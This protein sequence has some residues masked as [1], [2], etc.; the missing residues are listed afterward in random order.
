MFLGCFS[1]AVL[2]EEHTSSEEGEDLGQ[3]IPVDFPNVHQGEY[4]GG[5]ALNSAPSLEP[6][7]PGIVAG[8]K[9]LASQDLGAQFVHWILRERP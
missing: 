9:R 6:G 1:R 2:A 3:K 8:Q 5:S 4:S 7:K